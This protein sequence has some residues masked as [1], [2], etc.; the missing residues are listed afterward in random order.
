[1]AMQQ[2]AQGCNVIVIQAGDGLWL[3]VAVTGKTGVYRYARAG[4]PAPVRR[5]PVRQ[6][7]EAARSANARLPGTRGICGMAVPGPT[8]RARPM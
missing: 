6:R 5:Q 4:T 8:F 2:K 3:A 7:I 1:M